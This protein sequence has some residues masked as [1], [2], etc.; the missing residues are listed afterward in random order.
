M[1]SATW[2]KMSNGNDNNTH[3]SD[4][5]VTTQVANPAECLL[6][7]MMINIMTEEQ[8]NT[9]FE[10]KLSMGGANYMQPSRNIK[11]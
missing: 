7:D 10:Q 9:I 4:E 2:N 1:L 8:Q 5:T 6:E 11:S 3:V